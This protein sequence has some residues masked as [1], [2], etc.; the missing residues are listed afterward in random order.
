V[1]GRTQ[2]HL[3]WDSWAKPDDAEPEPWHHKILHQDGSPYD[4]A[5]V[6]FI[7]A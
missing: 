7:I 1:A 4:E 2:T 5:E 6:T 3:P